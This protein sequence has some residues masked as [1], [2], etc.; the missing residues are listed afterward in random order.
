M[1]LPWTYQPEPLPY[2]QALAEH[3]NCPSDNSTVILSCL[4]KVTVDQLFDLQLQFDYNPTAFP[5]LFI[6]VVDAQLSDAFFPD[7]PINLIRDKLYNNVPLLSGLTVEEGAVFYESLNTTTVTFDREFITNDLD[8]LVTNFTFLTGDEL[9]QV[10]SL[11]YDF[12]FSHIDLDNVTAIGEGVSAFISDSTFNTANFLTMTLLPSADDFPSLYTYVFAYQ[13]EFMIRP[14]LG[15]TTHSDELEYI[16][17]VAVD[18]NGILNAQD[19]VTSERILTLWTTFAKTGN[20]NPTSGDVISVTWEPVTSSDSVPYLQIDTEL[21]MGADFR[22]Q[23]M[24]FWNNTI[25]PIVMS[26]A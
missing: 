2:A 13:G 14:E 26:S 10:T 4:Q 1:V 21:S 15:V 23:R 19:N 9:T 18:D 3:A 7:Q 20:P 16:F 6:P 12:Y 25:L 11:V 24:Q 5:F 22:S 17:D 8:Q